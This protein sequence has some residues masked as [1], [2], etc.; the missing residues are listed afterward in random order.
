MKELLKIFILFIVGGTS[1]L[2][3]E[4]AYRGRTHWSMFLVGGIC[5]VL[6]GVVNEIFPWDMP[7]IWQSVA[8]ALMITAVEYLV[9]YIINIHLGW[10]VWNYSNLPFNVRGQI[11]LPFSCLWA[12]LSIPA[13]I[14]DDYLRYWFFGEEEP[15]YI[16]I[17]GRRQ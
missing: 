10:E 8:G 9:G 13:I 7:L 6:L 5:F 14:L 17:G 4:L 3:I 1:Y 2:L 16:L 15:E 12:L 11:C